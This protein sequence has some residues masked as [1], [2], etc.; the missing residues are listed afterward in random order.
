[1]ITIQKT[2][3]RNKLSLI[4]SCIFVFVAFLYYLYYVKDHMVEEI[5]PNKELLYNLL[6][7]NT[8]FAGFVYNMLGNMVE[9][10]A[11]K[12]IKELDDAGYIDSYFSPMYFSLFFFLVSIFIELLVVFFNI[13]W[14]L[15]ILLYLHQATSLLGL[16]FFGISTLKMRKMIN[17]VRRKI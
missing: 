16:T 15:S 7:V 12:D 14:Q 11:R 2:Y 3:R 4:L 8:I 1:M 10:S 6:T 17:K 13:K 5:V 9:F